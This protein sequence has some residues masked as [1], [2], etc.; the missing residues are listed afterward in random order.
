LKD[1]VII[2]VPQIIQQLLFRG[3]MNSKFYFYELQN[4]EVLDYIH[5][6]VCLMKK[7]EKGCYSICEPWAIEACNILYNDNNINV[8]LSEVHAQLSILQNHAKDGAKVKCLE[9]LTAVTLISYVDQSLYSIPLFKKAMDDVNAPNWFK[10]LKDKNLQFDKLH[11][12]TSCGTLTNLLLQKNKTTILL[13]H[14]DARPDI[15]CLIGDTILLGG[16]KFYSNDVPLEKLKNNNSSTDVDNVYK[17]KNL[18]IPKIGQRSRNCQEFENTYKRYK[19]SGEGTIRLL[20]TLPNSLTK[21]NP[22]QFE[23][24]VDRT[25][26]ILNVSLQNMGEFF[27]KETCLLLSNWYT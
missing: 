6:G 27:L 1:G 21:D 24:K 17:L 7:S 15:F 25:D 18:K 14:K 26:V 10:A 20:V 9:L 16:M 4:P 19:L 23:S 2:N 22:I 13:P 8:P 12:A 3:M 11:F 5:L